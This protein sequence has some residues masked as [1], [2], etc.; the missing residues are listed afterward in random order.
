M[1]D[2]DR[3]T[4]RFTMS[5][6]DDGQHVNMLMEPDPESLEAFERWLK[7]AYCNDLVW[8]VHAMHGDGA[9]AWMSTVKM[10]IYRKLFRHIGGDQYMVP[11]AD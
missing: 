4:G 5:V 3:I 9:T 8:R 7:F 1:K 6:L 2:K 10:E 11:G